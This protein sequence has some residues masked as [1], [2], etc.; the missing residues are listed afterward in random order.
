MA[1]DVKR[2]VEFF[3]DRD[4]SVNGPGDVGQHAVKRVEVLQDFIACPCLVGH[5]EQLHHPHRVRKTLQLG[6][7]LS[8]EGSHDFTT[9]ST[10]GIGHAEALQERVGQAHQAQ[11]T[12]NEVVDLPALTLH[13]FAGGFKIKITGPQHDVGKHLEKLHHG[14]VP[15]HRHHGVKHIGGFRDTEVG[16]CFIHLDGG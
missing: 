15:G 3:V 11:V 16:R 4:E 9:S 14:L 5:G 8:I 12:R 6:F 13:A 1:G 10:A 7:L 2:G